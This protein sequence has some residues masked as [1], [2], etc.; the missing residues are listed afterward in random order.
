VQVDVDVGVDIVPFTYPRN[1]VNVIA[2]LVCNNGP[3]Y[4]FYHVVVFE[5]MMLSCCNN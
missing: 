4:S 3:F 1:V 2:V 5:P